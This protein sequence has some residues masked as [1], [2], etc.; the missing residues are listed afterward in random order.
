MA[1]K[2]LSG[3]IVKVVAEGSDGL[4]ADFDP[5]IALTACLEKLG[6]E[7]RARL[8]KS[9]THVVVVQREAI[10]QAVAGVEEQLA[11]VGCCAVP[12]GTCTS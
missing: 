6:A 10:D 7:V 1:R 11:K 5:S 8:T 2:V 3:C 4:A 12:A 9:L